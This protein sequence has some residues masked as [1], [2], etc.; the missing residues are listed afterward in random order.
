MDGRPMRFTVL[1]SW[2]GL[3]ALWVAVYHFRVISYVG[4]TE[5]VR[6]GHLAVEFFFVLSGFVIT[7]AY[8]DRLLTTADRVKFMIR[9]FGRLYPLHLVTLLAVVAMECARWAISM[10]VGREVGGALFEGATD[11]ATLIPNLLLIH[12][13]GFWPDFTWN[14]P[15]WS[16]SVEFLLCGLF[17]LVFALP[18]RLMAVALFTAIGAAAF[19]YT[20]YGIAEQSESTTAVARGVYAFF[21]GGLVYYAYRW[22]KGRERG[23]HPWLEWLVIPVF[24][25]VSSVDGTLLPPLLFAAMIFIFAFEGGVV[26]RVLKQPSLVRLGEISYSIYL[27]HYLVVLAAFGA[28]AV[29]G[30]IADL[31]SPWIDA[32]GRLYG[33]L[34]T[35]VYLAVVIGLSAV[36]YALVESPGRNWFNGLANRP[37]RRRPEAS[38]GD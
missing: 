35:V 19:L 33:D 17:V 38:G 29:L 16:I 34:L 24:L 32:S 9:R 6:H 11:P 36:T 30:R 25:V 21:L 2:R 8:G 18:R 12:G 7:C 26:S 37:P 3:C 15:S 10:K 27:V 5:L 31:G 20:R 13:W 1:D 23:V 22:W 28:A 4:D 14:V